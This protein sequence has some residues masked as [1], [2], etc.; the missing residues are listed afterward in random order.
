MKDKPSRPTDDISPVESRIFVEEFADIVPIKQDKIP[1]QRDSSKFISVTKIKN[2]DN[3]PDIKQVTASFIFSDGYEGYFHPDEKIKY[4]KPGFDSHE[5]KR[6]ARGDYVP[7]LLLDLHGLT[8]QSA[9]LEI[10]AL[11]HAAHKQHVNCVCIMH[12]KGKYV[13]K[14]SVPNWLIQHPQVLGFHQATAEWGGKAALL[15]LLDVPGQHRKDALAK[16]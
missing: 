8:Q 3:Q 11:L 9:K 5:I 10:A 6:L 2:R 4:I 15:V 12:G 7:E 16:R 13:L 14:K 1:P